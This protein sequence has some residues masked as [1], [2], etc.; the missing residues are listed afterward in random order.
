MI[1]KYF[2]LLLLFSAPVYSNTFPWFDESLTHEQRINA[3]VNAMTLEEKTAQMLNYTP[4][5]ERLGVPAYDWWNEALHGVARNGRA[6]VFPQTIALAATFDTELMYEVAT[7]ISDEARAKFNVAQARGNRGRYAGLTFWS[8]NIN[9][10]RDPRWGRGMETF[11]EDPF[12]TTQFGVTMARG[13]Q[14]D[15]PKYLKTAATAKHFAVHSGPEASRHNFD[16]VATQK[17]L[18]ETYLP[19]FEALIQ[20]GKVETVMAAYNMVNGE[21]ANGS[22]KLL[23]E[24]LR[25]QLGFDGHVVSDCWGLVDLYRSYGVAKNPMEAAALA[26]KSGVNL[27]CGVTYTALAGAVKNGLVEESLVD[28]RLKTLMKTRFKL[29]LFDSSDENPFNKIPESVVASE[30]HTQLA[31]RSALKSIVLLQNKNSV[32]PL[33]SSVNNIYVTGPMATS[34]EAMLGNYYGLN[35]NVVTVLEGLA[36]TVS[37]GVSLD[38]RKGVMPYSDNINP[39]DWA[40]ND[41]KS[42]QALIVVLGVDTAYEGEEG[43]AIASADLGD[44]ISLALPE[45]QLKFLRKLSLDKTKPII[46]VVTGGSPILLD[47]VA[48]LADAILFAWYPGQQGGQ[49]IADIIFGRHSPSARLPITFPMSEEQLP[50]YEDYNMA[51]RT[52]RYMKADPMYPFGYGL[53]YSKVKYEK[54]KISGLNNRRYHP[55]EKIGVT[56]TIKNKG[57]FQIDEI[58]QLYLSGPGAGELQPLYSLKGFDSVTLKPGEAKTVEFTLEPKHLK[59]VNKSGEVGY[60]PGN[61]TI[62]IGGAL[63]SKR[64]RQLGVGNFVS[65]TFKLQ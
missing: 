28:Q 59:M 52:Y 21:P 47:E 35:G 55:G 65:G 29:G 44:R 2:A 15:H 57:E 60:L 19:A 9:I 7:A 12:L 24:L 48:E 53:S 26:I 58:A 13:L 6:T 50:A 32:L 46:V 33:D 39:H 5:I 62:T 49:A 3:L 14:G 61:Y 27:N 56:V 36:N 30:E 1:S 18:W 38:Y 41:A 17:D 51:N 45:N 4:A 43:A 10:F 20:E 63:P 64:S 8:P 40:T 16:A 22:F 31:Y 37:S 25:D 54:L 42:A 11:G 23:Q 34:V